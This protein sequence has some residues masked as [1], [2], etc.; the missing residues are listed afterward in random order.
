VSEELENTLRS[1]LS[2]RGR[3]AAHELCLNTELTE[4][5]ISNWLAGRRALPCHKLVAAVGWLISQ[6]RISVTINL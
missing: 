2:V 6:G 5:D 4:S 1:Y 3:G